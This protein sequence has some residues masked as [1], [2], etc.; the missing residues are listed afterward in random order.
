MAMTESMPAAE[1]QRKHRGRPLKK[2]YDEASLRARL[3]ADVAEVYEY[4]GE[5]R[6]TAV[7]LQMST[8]R[9]KKLLITA[10]T[11]EYEMTDRIRRL[12]EEGHSLA[13][14]G[15]ILNLKRSSINSYLPYTR[16]PYKEAEISANADRCDLYRRRRAAVRAI[17]DTE[18][19]WN[20]LLLFAGYPFETGR[21]Q[22]FS[23]TI[24]Q[25]ADGSLRKEL[26]LK[27]G[28]GGQSLDF[29]KIAAAWQQLRRRGDD[30]QSRP[31]AKEGPEAAEDE[32]RVIFRR[33][34]L[35]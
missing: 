18:S 5:I 24:P 22:T 33:L 11:L 2:H 3:L 23:Y 32:I 9:V 34:G 20:C 1:A 21:G 15:S 10:G 35:L 7:E 4:T 19:L 13:E 31:A 8:V 26:L 12:Q 16:L 27:A 25:E 29:L 30:K 28:T 6:A 17:H 14:I